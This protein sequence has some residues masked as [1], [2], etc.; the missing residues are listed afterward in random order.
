MSTA[1]TTNGASSSAAIAGIPVPAGVKLPIY[2]DNH[3]TT[4]MDP[5]VLEAMMPYFTETFGNAASRNHSFGWE[6]EQAVEQ[7]RAQIA[8]LIGATSKEI[9]FTSGAT[10][11][12]N[13]AI[14]G[15]AE[16]Y[17]ERG[18]HIIT[19]ATEHKAV[20]DTCKR[21]EKSGYQVT[22]L[23]VK[24]DGLI[25]I[26]DLKNAITDK[27]ILV[28]I[29]IANNEIGVVQPVEEIGKLCH[30]RG[31]LFH[32][33]G[34][35]AVGKIPVDVNAMQIDALSLT[36]HKIYGPKGVGAL[37]VRRR[38]PRVQISEQ[39]NGGGHERG[40]RSGTLNVPGI[41]G[42]GKACE[43]A[44]EEMESEA[45]R[46]TAMRDRLKHKL[47][48]SLDY[49]HVNGTMERHLPGNLNMSFVY[50]E[51]ESLLMGINDVAV[52]SGSA[53]T[54]ATLEP[55]YVLKA[56][57]LGDDVAHSSIRFGLGRFNTDAEVDYVAD[58]VIDVVQKLRELSPLYEMV[59]EGIDLTKIEWAAH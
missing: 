8:K 34:V 18:N 24:A 7:A 40:M 23:P 54:S 15:I 10:E 46:L 21:L 2:M 38:N 9:I 49:I 42:L 12:N 43:L 58:K 35:Q 39:I 44:G 28:T 17:R 56:L 5:R 32:T 47:E 50:V 59:K 55:S 53:C 31:V 51:G 30:E 45:K 33:D 13:L 11:S 29:M 22:Y 14:K 37:Y 6:A 25:D 57:G 48:S 3:A 19:Q 26:E 16:M 27:T 52:S 4:R 41:V 20:L 36:A 1:T